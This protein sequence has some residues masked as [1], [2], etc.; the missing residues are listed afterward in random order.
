MAQGLR[1]LIGQRPRLIEPKASQSWTLR[2]FAYLKNDEIHHL[3]V[4]PTKSAT[5]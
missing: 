5:A 4:T 3:F 2:A 1:Q